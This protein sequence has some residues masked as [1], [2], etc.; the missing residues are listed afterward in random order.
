MNPRRFSHSTICVEEFT[1]TR[2]FSQ[3][4]TI[5]LLLLVAGCSSE[6]KEQEGKVEDKDEALTAEAAKRALLEMDPKAIRAG[7]RVPRPKDEPI[8]VLGPD[9]I[10][11]GIWHCNLREKTFHAETE[12]PNADRH[13]FNEVSGVFQ[14]SQDGHWV[15]K[16]TET[17]SGH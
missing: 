7:V 5:A 3:V 8:D 2:A 15:A 1:M 13:R 12:Y 10:A 17:L 9:E 4:G 14:L 11:V 16:V 6:R